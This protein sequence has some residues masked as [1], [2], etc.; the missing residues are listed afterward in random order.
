MYQVTHN[1]LYLLHFWPILW[2]RTV[3]MI[4]VLRSTYS[5]TC[6]TLPTEFYETEFR[7][8][9]WSTQN[10][11][12]ER[13]FGETLGV[14]VYLRTWIHWHITSIFE[15]DVHSSICHLFCDVRR[16]LFPK[17]F[18]FCSIVDMF[19][20][21]T[22]I[23]CWNAK[24]VLYLNGIKHGHSMLLLEHI[25]HNFL[26]ESLTDFFLCVSCHTRSPCCL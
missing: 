17:F 25:V 7:P 3:E 11:D 14:E 12:F 6:S 20:T 4:Q 24:S 23:K 15:P 22:N 21:K 19:H 26:P 10:H 16:S 5:N 18:C 9:W 13:W 8:L 2:D 1:F